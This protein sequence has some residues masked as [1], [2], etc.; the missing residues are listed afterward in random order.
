MDHDFLRYYDSEIRYLK[1]AAK[2]FAQKFPDVARQLGIDSVSLKT[3]E[4]VEQL[5]QGFAF[6]MAQVRRKIDDD[7]P[8]LTEPLLSH[9]L[10]VV[11]RT[12]PPRRWWS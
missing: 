6:M 5:F 2:E 8:E 12:L 9:L 10:P 1:E 3:D 7:I 4:S 11:N